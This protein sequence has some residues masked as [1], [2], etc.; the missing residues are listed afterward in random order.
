MLNRKQ[1]SE[2][3]KVFEEGS[4]PGSGLLVGQGVKESGEY[5]AAIVVG[6]EQIKGHEETFPEEDFPICL[7]ID[8]KHL[9]KHSAFLL[10]FDEEIRPIV[11]KTKVTSLLLSA[12]AN[13]D[14][15][16]LLLIIREIQVFMILFRPEHLLL[17]LSVQ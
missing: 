15:H 13:T 8:A 9:T 12:D 6:M 7:K 1:A 10:Y 11:G 14:R 16:E 3:A 2:L 4:Q 5:I 17:S